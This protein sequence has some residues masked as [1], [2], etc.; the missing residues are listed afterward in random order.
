MS[1][2]VVLIA[3]IYEEMREK[4]MPTPTP[5]LMSLIDSTARG[6]FIIGI[7]IFITIFL[8]LYFK[9]VLPK[10]TYYLGFLVKKFKKGMQ[11]KK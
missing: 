10:T 11:N 5:T 4:Y 2:R 8:Y 1:N 3:G 6:I 9:F 7:I